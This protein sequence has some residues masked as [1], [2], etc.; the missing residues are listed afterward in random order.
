MPLIVQKLNHLFCALI[1][2]VSISPLQAQNIQENKDDRWKQLH[3]LSREE[4]DL[5][6]E[7]K[8]AYFAG[9]APVYPVESIAE[10]EPMAGVLV[11][12]PGELRFNLLAEIS[13]KDTVFVL[14][15]KGMENSFWSAL[16]LYSFEKNHI[17][18]IPAQFNSHWTRDYGPIFVAGKDSIGI[19]D[20]VYNRVRPLDNEIPRFLAGELNIPY[21]SMKVVHA[22]GNYMTDGWG[23]A[24]STPIVYSESYSAGISKAE[25]DQQSN[26]FLG[27]RKYHII[28]NPNNDYIHHIDCFAKF[29]DVDKVM[30]RSVPSTHPQYNEIEE[31]AD[32]FLNQLSSWG[33]N[34][35]V[36]RVYTP[37][38]EPYT[39][40]FILNKRV[41]VPIMGTDHDNDALQAYREAMPGYEVLG[42]MGSWYSTDALHCRVHEIA[43]KQMIR[44]KHN[45]VR[46]V[47]GAD[48]SFVTISA[49]IKAYS[50]KSLN[51]DSVQVY[52]K[53]DGADWQSKV[54][55]AGNEN[56]YETTLSGL[57][58]ESKIE[59]YIRAVDE[60]GRKATHPLLGPVAA[61]RFPKKASSTWVSDKDL[62]SE[63][64]LYPNPVNDFLNILF[65]VIAENTECRV[66]LH[67]S[68]GRCLFDN[69]VHE[70]TAGSLDLR[71]YMPGIYIVRVKVGV[72][73]STYKVVKL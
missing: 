27:I 63:V 56:K 29:L 26:T 35:H 34:Y 12:Y 52:Y 51:P 30:V 58:S 19:T 44:I 16:S 17:K 55:R 61:H 23:V 8:S 72:S 42:F 47:Q 6:V 7:L 18:I 36:F 48:Q 39:N 66:S 53:S 50:G 71:G 20:F 73:V 5:K 69:V 60:S 11:T 65:P 64:R 70:K 41:F 10:F 46:S 57:S 4:L 43:D 15:K 62:S 40:S 59:Y 9:E 13:K 32:Y 68:D 22:G 14:M 67:S 54:L 1:L 21:Y 31:V 49:Q 38:N 37:N 28:D 2:I 33:N 25:V 24:A 3:M 45:P